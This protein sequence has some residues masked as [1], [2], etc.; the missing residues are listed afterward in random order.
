MCVCVQ[1]IL[2]MHVSV[3]KMF[4]LPSVMEKAMWWQVKHRSA[5][6]KMKPRIAYT[7]LCKFSREGE[8]SEWVS[9]WNNALGESKFKERH[10]G[11]GYMHVQRELSPWILEEITNPPFFFSF[12]LDSI[13]TWRGFEWRICP[14][15][16]NIINAP[17]LD[18][19]WWRSKAKA[20]QRHMQLHLHARPRHFNPPQLFVPSFVTC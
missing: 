9:E 2:Y 18:V 4:C 11:G 5:D 14:R 20:V 1:Y 16:I 19:V 6:K 13:I 3:L 10:R 8:L 17:N 12:W 15:I 7:I